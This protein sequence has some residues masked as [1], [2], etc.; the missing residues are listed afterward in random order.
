MVEEE[1][2]LRQIPGVS[3]L[4]RQVKAQRGNGSERVEF[5]GNRGAWRERPGYQAE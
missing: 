5:V 4:R 3:E 2:E 1:Q